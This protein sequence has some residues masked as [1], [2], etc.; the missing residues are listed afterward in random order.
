MEEKEVIIIWKKIGV[1]R[2][3]F[4]FDCGGDSMGDTE[5]TFFD[6]EDN[7]IP[8]SSTDELDCYFEDTIYDKVEFYVNSDGHYI[9]ENGKVI[10]EIDDEDEDEPSFSYI[11]NSLS[12]YRES[13]S[14]KTHVKLNKEMEQFIRNNVFNINGAGK[15]VSTNFKR[16]LILTDTDI[17]LLKQIENSIMDTATEYEPSL[18]EGELDSDDENC[19]FTTNKE[20]QEIKIEED[21]DILIWVDHDI[22]I[23]KAQEEI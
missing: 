13:I 3:E 14:N 4:K 19:R 9:G 16:D 20:G 11:K 10:I 15:S 12:E 21:G 17:A 1:E 6:K 2:A 7:E 8:K 22:I 18:S 23:R 5:L